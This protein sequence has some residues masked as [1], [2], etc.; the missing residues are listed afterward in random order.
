MITLELTDSMAKEI[1]V[2][3]GIEKIDPAINLEEA[4]GK[5]ADKAVELQTEIDELKPKAELGDTY[6]AGI[7]EEV[8]QLETKV[9]GLSKREPLKGFETLVDKAEL[10]TL[11]DLRTQKEAELEQ[12]A[13]ALKCVDCGSTNI[14]R[15]Q[16]ELSDDDP[17]ITASPS[18]RNL[19]SVRV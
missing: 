14:T 10:E 4:V 9:A 7:R 1:A 11:Q 17:K 2:K 5:L 13:P 8:M 6:I 3:L 15:R 12:I 18:R 19:N 16:S